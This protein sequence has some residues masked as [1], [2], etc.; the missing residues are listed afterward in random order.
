MTGHREVPADPVVRTA[1][2]LLPVPDHEAGFWDRL[3]EAVDSEPQ[4]AV[5]TFTPATQSRRDQPLRATAPVVELAPATNLGV[6][7]P[8]LR[9]GSNL[10]L[11]VVAVA[12]AVMV[13][14]AGAALVRERSGGSSRDENVAARADDPGTAESSIAGDAGAEA[15]AGATLAAP[16]DADEAVA[17]VTAWLAALEDGD[18]A[19]AWEALGPA[20]RSHWGSQA[21][22]AEQR[23]ALAEGY[24]A[25]SAATPDSVIVTSVPSGAD[26]ALVVVTLVGTVAQEGQD[27][28]RADAFPVRLGGEHPQLELWSSAGPIE[29]VVPSAATE[30]GTRTPV[31]RHDELVVVVPAGTSAPLLRIDEETP[32]VCGEAPGSTLSPLDQAPGQRCG[33]QP[34]DGLTTGSHVL[35]VVLTSSDGTEIS[36]TSVRFEVR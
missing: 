18:T 1:L 9:R 29:V 30:G 34:A 2:Q 21:A 19:A 14:V 26:D 23:S 16:A 36:A 33:Y 17:A 3:S 6:V 25:W 15:D 28:Q 32:V 8:A 35:T 31:D 11:S 13:V 24:G 5:A 27:Q 10:I 22:F 4:A 20:S 7:P 12:A